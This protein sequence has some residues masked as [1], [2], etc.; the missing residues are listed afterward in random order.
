MLENFKFWLVESKSKPFGVAVAIWTLRRPYS[1][2][3][4]ILSQVTFCFL[5]KLSQI[6]HGLGGHRPHFVFRGKLLNFFSGTT[7]LEASS[8]STTTYSRRRANF[9]RQC[10]EWW[11]LCTS[12]FSYDTVHSIHSSRMQG[13]LSTPGIIFITKV[14]KKQAP[15][16]CSWADDGR[17]SGQW[18]ILTGIFSLLRKRER[19]QYT[20]NPEM[21]MHYERPANTFAI[22]DDMQN[23]KWAY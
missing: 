16:S 21:Y 6:P 15:S 1:S 5:E 17:K 22:W 19:T 13:L 8:F 20:K 3:R 23:I 11:C 18:Q 9:K 2:S 14:H 4:Y 7:L 12:S 10:Q